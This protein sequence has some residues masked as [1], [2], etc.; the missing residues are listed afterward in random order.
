MTQPK[1]FV[2]ALKDHAVSEKQLQ[3]CKNSAIKHGWDVE[4]SWGVYGNT[5]NEDSWKGI[6]VT[7]LLDKPTMN[8]PGVQGCFFSHW[9]LWNKCIELNESIIILEHDA[10]ICNK[11]IPLNINSDIIKLHERYKPKKVRF[12]EHTGNWSTSGHAYLITPSAAKKL[13]NFSRAT[14]GIPVDILMGDNVVKVGHLGSPE[15]VS[16]QNSY[17]STTHL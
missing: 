10:I 1:T 3:D 8:L 4:V 6:G 9:A 5:V 14:G 16:R 2:I 17:S 11:W 13:I 7:P 12:D 15:L